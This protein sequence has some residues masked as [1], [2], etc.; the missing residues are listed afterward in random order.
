MNENFEVLTAKA[1][2]NYTRDCRKQKVNKLRLVKRQAQQRWAAAVSSSGAMQRTHQQGDERIF[3]CD[4]MNHSW[5]KIH[6]THQAWFSDLVAYCRVCGS[7]N[8]KKGTMQKECKGR[9]I[10]RAKK[11]QPTLFKVIRLM[12]QGLPPPGMKGWPRAQDRRRLDP[13]P[14]IVTVK[15]VVVYRREYQEHFDS[16][17]AAWRQQDREED[18]EEEKEKKRDAA[19]ASLFGTLW[20]GMEAVDAECDEFTA[21]ETE[22]KR[23]RAVEEER[24]EGKQYKID[25]EN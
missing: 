7:V 9:P 14:L 16:I 3:D 25:K 5:A 13:K 24:H 22:E 2:G 6:S 12:S 20:E 1:R 15:G 4:C 11:C 23:K 10:R 21:K 17:E 8:S 18:E 19:G